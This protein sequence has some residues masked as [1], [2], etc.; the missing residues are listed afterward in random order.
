MF[1]TMPKRNLPFNY[2]VINYLGGPGDFMSDEKVLNW[3]GSVTT[4]YLREWYQKHLLPNFTSSF[5]SIAPWDYLEFSRE[6][7]FEIASLHLTA[8]SAGMLMECASEKAMIDGNEGRLNCREYTALIAC[9]IVRYGIRG[10]HFAASKDQTGLHFAASL[11][12]GTVIVDLA[13][14]PHGYFAQLLGAEAPRP[15]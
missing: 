15:S 2:A 8:R 12:L 13:E 11:L 5:F 14:H 1:D 9:L 3:I 10:G 6:M 4:P 7:E